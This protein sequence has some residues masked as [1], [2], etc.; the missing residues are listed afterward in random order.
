MSTKLKIVFKWLRPYLISEAN[1]DKGT[2]KLK[3]L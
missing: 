1:K 3:D 2:Y